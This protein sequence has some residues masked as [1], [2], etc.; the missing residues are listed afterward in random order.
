MA[1]SILAGLPPVF[2]LYTS[3]YPVLLYT[4]M[5]TSRHISVGTFPVTSLLTQSVIV[6]LT[7]SEE[8]N[9]MLTNTTTQSV[10]TTVSFSLQYI[11]YQM[12]KMWSF[13]KRISKRNLPAALNFYVSK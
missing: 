12:I 13:A 10:E 11:N 2:G 8:E 4:F 3:F 9:L 7:S 1:F 6:R 5:G